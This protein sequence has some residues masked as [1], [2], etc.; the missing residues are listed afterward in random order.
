MGRIAFETGRALRRARRMRGLTLRKVSDL[1]EARIKPT[2]IAGYER[3]ERSISLERFCELCELYSVPPHSILGD[4][5]RSVQGIAEPDIDLAQLESLGS[6]EAALVVGF[7]RQI[8]ALRRDEP[9]ET[10]VLRSGDLEVLA[11]A[12]G[13]KPYEL[14]EV[15]G[16]GIRS[17]TGGHKDPPGGQT[18]GAE[19]HPSP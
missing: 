7:I 3:G 11:T 17:Q 4:I 9:V 8:R 10:I 14:V 2:S 19:G 16:P 13:K 18:S 1:T 5:W 6:A 12:A 15:L